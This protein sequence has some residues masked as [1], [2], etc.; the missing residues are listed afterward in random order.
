[1]GTGPGLW[2]TKEIVTKNKWSVRIRSSADRAHR[3]TTFSILIPLRTEVAEPADSAKQLQPIT[4][5]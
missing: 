5:A 1:M 3:G 4:A 2:V